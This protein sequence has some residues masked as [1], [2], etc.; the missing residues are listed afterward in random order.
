MRGAR[1]VRFGLEKMRGCRAVVRL[2]HHIVIW[3][4]ER[5]VQRGVSSEEWRA[6]L[7]SRDGREYREVF[8]AEAWSQGVLGEGGLRV[9]ELRRE[10]L[11]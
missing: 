3:G 5:L 2:C 1:L 7:L 6:E 9:L 4:A 10:V 11:E 8:A